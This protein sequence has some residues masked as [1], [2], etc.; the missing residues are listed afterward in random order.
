[1]FRQRIFQRRPVQNFTWNEFRAGKH[2]L[3]MALA[4]IVVNDGALPGGQQ[5]LYDNASNVPSPARNEYS[6]SRIYS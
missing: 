6:H 5:F 4:E 1:M 2:R 3:A